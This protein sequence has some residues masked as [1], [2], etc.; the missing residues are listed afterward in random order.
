MLFFLYVVLLLVFLLLYI[1][2]KDKSIIITVICSF[3]IINFIVNPD[4]CIQGSLLGSQL[5]FYKVF[6][7]LFPFLII[8]NIIMFYN[9][10]N[11][12][13]KLFGKI[14][15][16]PLGLPEECS[17]ALIV[18]ILCGY[19]LGAKYSCELYEKGMI[20]LKTCTRLLNIASNAS[21]LFTI[22]SVGL[23][24]LNN[25]KLGYIL[26]L[27]NYISCFFMSLILKDK[28]YNI[29][30]GKTPIYIISD[31]KNFGDALKVAIENSINTSLS[32]GGFILLFCILIKIIKNSIIT[33]T[34][35]NNLSNLFNINK[36]LIEGLLYGMVEMT[37]GC[38]IISTSNT[39]NEIKVIFTG[40]LL[41]FSGLCIVLQ[42]NSFMSKNN[43]SLWVY[44]KNKFTQG[45]VCSLCSYV[46]YKLLYNRITLQVF[47]SNSNNYNSSLA[48]Y[49]ITLS[50]LILPL[51]IFKNKKHV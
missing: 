43:I 34:I 10:I 8:T 7:S 38:N 31:R 36:G 45:I 29:K 9:G 47:N 14:L 24:M 32:V 49:I 27:G 22:G 23:S 13:S 48:M 21:P 44:I 35:L 1:F 12:Y 11:L 41:G 46:I 28:S 26:L 39:S 3:I 51:F 2:A 20:D 25:T 15:C 6:P 19:P 42:C 5:F 16:L 4:S 18:S 50:I 30:K 40:F 17:F 33:N 37:N